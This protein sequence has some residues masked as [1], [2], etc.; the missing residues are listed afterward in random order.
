MEIAPQPKKIFFT[1]IYSDAKI[2]VGNLLWKPNAG[3]ATVKSLEEFFCL[4]GTN[5]LQ[6]SIFFAMYHAERVI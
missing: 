1:R 2:S 5:F 3:R 4:L 6:M